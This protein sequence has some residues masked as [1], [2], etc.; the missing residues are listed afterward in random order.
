ML[1]LNA[2]A[3]ADFFWA[4]WERE[5]FAWQVALADRVLAAGAE[6]TTGNVDGSDD[7]AGWPEAIAL[8][9]A[10]GKTACMDIAVYA[11]AAQADRLDDCQPL[12]APRRIFFVVDCRV[13][14]DEAFERARALALRLAQAKNGIL[15]TVAD[16]LRKLSDCDLPLAAHQLRGGTLRSEAWARSPVQ[17]MIVASTVDQVGSRLLFRGYGPG[18]G[19]RPVHASLVGNDSLILLDEAHCA[20]PFLETLLAV[21]HYR[22]WA[23]TPLLVP[24]QMTV[25]SATPPPQCSDVFCDESGQGN[26]PEHPLGQRQ[27]AEKPARLVTAEKAKGKDSQASRGELA[28]VLVE[29]AEN[30]VK[31]WKSAASAPAV[32]LFCN[33]VDTARKAH[34]LLA[35]KGVQV[36]LLTG[37]MRPFDK[38]GVIDVALDALSVETSQTR[39]FQQP[40]FVVATQTLEVGA[41]LDFDLL[42]TECASLDALRQRCG[43]LNRMG[44]AIHAR[45]SIVVRAD[46]ASDSTDDP[47]Y[48]AALAKTWKWLNE[49]ADGGPVDFGIAQLAPRLPQAAAQAQLNAPAEHAPVLLPAHVDALAQ[50]AP[51]PWPS[52]EVALFLHGS[53]SGPADVQ[54][55]W[56]ADLTGDE[57]NWLDT[58]SLCPPT[59][60]ECLSVPY[61]QM[62]C[63]LAGEVGE[64]GADVEGSEVGADSP[65]APLRIERPVIRWRGREKSDILRDATELRPGDVLVVPASLAGWEELATLGSNPV[66]DWGDRAYG[67]MRGKALLRLHPEVLNQWPANAALER[68]RVLAGNGSQRLDEEPQALAEDLR[69]A[70]AEWADSLGG[71]RWSWLSTMAAALATDNKLVRG[72]TAHPTGGLVLTGSV[73]LGQS[74]QQNLEGEC[75]RFSDEDDMASSGN[76]RSLLLEPMGDAPCHLEGV[77]D[78]AARHA[79]LC[80]L[81]KELVDILNSAG[82]GHDLG[83]AD[84]RFQAWLNGGNPWARGPLLAK[85]SGMKQSRDES[86]KARERAGYPEGGRH[87]LLSVRLL[88]SVPDALPKDETLR[89]L[90]L[91]LVESHHGHCRPFAPVVEDTAPVLVNVDFQGRHYTA[92]SATGIE[93]IDAGPAE[94]YWRLTR[95]YGWWGLAWL[96][97]LLRLGDHRRSEWE[98]QARWSSHE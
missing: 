68:L 98:E 80:G 94:R 58:I 63:W 74:D 86:R 11:L 29:E 26:D 97:T 25:M 66:A 10:A 65:Q 23:E 3:F 4:L 61:T 46:Q 52:P 20:Q 38:E 50:T 28:K 32:V 19:M 85:S 90:L 21:R 31:D 43:R 15:K 8:P 51:E 13:I 75:V 82:G 87:E 45:A 9:T 64:A 53:S 54:V 39:R 18:S 57:A 5:P 7:K 35:G 6:A 24:L 88:E 44:R 81:P 41:N 2:L 33:R 83:K 71:T 67:R 59:A 56:R 92:H 62:R 37:R 72:I 42:V 55:C 96:E 93:R 84:P 69:A 47:V 73:A 40:R 22:T 95:R 78:Y 79:R 34:A 30:L 49:Q 12:T 91:H 60:P 14:V 77:G 70:L 16:R 17:P 27:L 1:E 48:G 76:F 89:D 36:D